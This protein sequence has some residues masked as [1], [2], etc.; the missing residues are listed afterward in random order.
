MKQVSG[1][2]RPIRPHRRQRGAAAAATRT[3]VG[4]SRNDDLADAIGRP[5]RKLGLS[6][7][8]S[9]AESLPH[10]SK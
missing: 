2:Q 6:A 7:Y 4:S 5:T 10:C 1:N 3:V 9:I 8:N